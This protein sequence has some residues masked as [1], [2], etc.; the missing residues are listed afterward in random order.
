MDRQRRGTVARLAR[1]AAAH[2]GATRRHPPLRRVAPRE[3]RPRRPVWDGRLVARAGG[4]AAQLRRRLVPRPRHDA[5]SRDPGTRSRARPRADVLRLVLEVRLDARDPLPHRLL[6]GEDR[7]ARRSVRGDHRPR[8]VARGARAGARLP[9]DLP[10]RAVDRGALLGALAVR[11]RAGRPDGRG[12][13][14][15]PRAGAG[16]A[17]GLPFRRGQSRLRAREPPRRGL[18]RRPRQDLHRRRPR[19]FRPLG[20]AADRRVDR[21]ARERAHPRARRVR[22]RR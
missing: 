9:R 15:D 2:P 17:R 13:G 20:R 3:G 19:R 16:D 21:Q 4:V 10:R 14:A 18:A 22:G 6:L 12:R 11:D 1:R 5:S 8:V 7:R